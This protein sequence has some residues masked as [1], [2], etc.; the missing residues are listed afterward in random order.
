MG[1]GG[2]RWRWFGKS[3][4]QSPGDPRTNW[5]A[6]RR[7]GLEMWVY[8]SGDGERKDGGRLSCLVGTAHGVLGRS[9]EFSERATEDANMKGAHRIKKYVEQKV[10]IARGPFEGMP[11]PAKMSGTS[12][13]GPRPFNFYF[14]SFSPRADRIARLR[15]C[16]DVR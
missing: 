4:R 8:E 7:I 16:E 3:E 10:R 2:R 1:G 6:R 9:R 13:Q 15:R 11:K 12:L 14:F 5:G